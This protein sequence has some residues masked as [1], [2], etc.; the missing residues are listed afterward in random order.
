MRP[1]E[2]IVFSEGS[3]AER[4]LGE[5]WSFLEPTGVWTDGEASHRS[6]SELNRLP[7]RR[8]ELVLA[9]SAFLTPDHPELE[10]EVSARRR[11]T[12]RSSLSSWRGPAAAPRSLAGGRARQVKRSSSSA[13]PIQRGRSIWDWDDDTRRLGIFWSGS[14][15]GRGRGA[16]PA[17]DVVREKSA[18]LRRRLGH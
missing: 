13:S 6:C 9:A 11:A 8:A 18:N 16:R 12:C 10:V 5:G 3:G 15:S 4:V 7:L 2:K 17:A 1:G 14:W